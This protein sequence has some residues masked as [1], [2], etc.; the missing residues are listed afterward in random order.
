MKCL[1]PACKPH[2]RCFSHQALLLFL[3]SMLVLLTSTLIAEGREYSIPTTPT[4]MAES[5]LYAQPQA[6]ETLSPTIALD[7]PLGNQ[8]TVEIALTNITSTTLTPRLYEAWQEPPPG[9]T[10]PLTGTASTQEVVDQQPRIDPQI[11]A[12]LAAAPDHR[13]EFFVYLQDYPDLSHAY[14]I[15]DWSERGWYVYQTLRRHAAVSQQAIRAWLDEQHISYHPFWIVN[16]LAVEGTAADLQALE[17]RADVAYL[18]AN[19]LVSLGVTA[20][21]SA[22][23]SCKA[24]E[25][26]MC[27]NI[28]QINAHRVWKDYGISGQGITVAHIDS[29]V[30]LDHPALVQQYRGYRGEDTFT[31]AYNWYDPVNNTTSPNDAGNH[32]THTMGTMVARGDGTPDQPTVGVAPGVRWMAARGC[33]STTCKETNLVEAAEWLLAP[34]NPDGE[35][36]RP[37]LRPHI[38]NNSWA[39]AQSNSSEYREFTTA[40]HA[41]GIFPVFSAGNTTSIACGSITS[42]GDY[43][44]V[45]GVGATTSSDSIAY[46]SRVGPS[47]DQRIKP[48]ITAPG[49]SI[50][51]TFAGSGLNYGTLNGTSMA[52]PHVAATVALLW[53]ANPALIADYDATYDLLTSTAVPRID[54]HYTSSRFDACKADTIPNN[55]YG[56]GRIDA[57][58]GVT[59][60]RVDVPWLTIPATLPTMK[61]GETITFEATIDARQFANADT[62]HARILV[63]TGDL[64]QTPLAIAVMPNATMTTA[65]ATIQGRIFA[66][67]GSTPLTGKIAVK[68]GPETT[69][70]TTTDIYQ[71]TLPV[72][73]T[74]AY[75][76]T[77]SSTGYVS[78]TQAITVE[79]DTNYTLD[80]TLSMRE[81]HIKVMPSAITT[82]L[83]Y[84]ERHT[85][86]ITITN[87]GTL[88]LNYSA[89]IPIQYY[90]VSR[91]DQAKEAA[92]YTWRTLPSTA[93]TLSLGDDAFSKKI[94]LPFDFPIDGAVV[95]ALAIGSNG[96]MVFDTIKPTEGF[97]P[98]CQPVPETVGRALMPLRTDLDPSYGGSIRYGEVDNGFLITYADIALHEKPDK[99]FTFQVFL[100]SEGDVTYTYQDVAIIPQYVSVGIQL[101]EQQTQVIGCDST[102]DIASG[103]SIRFR[104]NPSSSQWVSLAKSMSDGESKEEMDVHILDGTL[105]PGK[106]TVLALHEQWVFTSYIQPYQSRVEISSDDPDMPSVTIPISVSMLPLTHALTLPMEADFAFTTTQGLTF[107]IVG[108]ADVVDEETLLVYT[109]IPTP[110]LHPS[111]YL[112]AG[113]AFR[114]RAYRDQQELTDFVFSTPLAITLEYD[115]TT[116][117]DQEDVEM[118]M[119]NRIAGEKLW[120]KALP[121]LTSNPADNR[122]T[123]EIEQTGEFGLYYQQQEH[124]L[125][126]PLVQRS[127]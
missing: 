75:T 20:E 18:R 100:T 60:A 98:R 43:A 1:P 123:L 36:P 11:W 52:S 59:A 112:Y 70:D 19:E 119:F 49:D 34:T 113:H 15:H 8:Q 68:A 58:A 12:D 27:W 115:D 102:L 124:N 3:A 23:S 101:S 79:E 73:D 2:A 54:D 56:Y 14:G 122:V 77:A 33:G 44:N 111:D 90:A 24:D 84:R 126:I 89:T 46:F 72:T 74:Q 96:V 85:A 97:Y 118:M 39:S 47:Y 80:F 17:A 62:Y 4:P 104:P 16:A 92:A 78:Q 117:Q 32:G 65:Y 50:V 125:Y 94:D 10:F 51:S 29:G 66:K 22:I 30:R 28:K 127:R 26:G 103:L 7:I 37:D 87:V 86:P 35:T 53:S 121:A 120:L 93:D 108:S 40:W 5:S 116:M 81:P 82:T 114:L 63:S 107:R 21:P 83:A 57:Y 76:L 71:I 13:A 41:A 67:D 88:P 99:T 25:Q 38:I 110:T 55:I 31:H 45:V 61:A 9:I 106:Q 48:D 95:N 69:I 64:Q 109:E 6:F 91:S 42:P 105:E